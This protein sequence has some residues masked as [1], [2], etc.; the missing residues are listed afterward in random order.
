MDNSKIVALAL[1]CVAALLVIMA[2][3]SCASDIQEQNK[4]S[5]GSSYSSVK[6]TTNNA[7][8]R[9]IE[10]PPSPGQ[11]T[12]VYI[13]QTEANTESQYEV[14]TDMLGRVVET[15]PVTS[16]ENETSAEAEESEPETTLSLID[17]MYENERQ[18]ATNEISGFY[19]GTPEQQHKKELENATFPDDFSITID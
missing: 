7:A 4:K 2:G 16:A 10:D 9:L 18:N 12:P 11:G 13:E 17:Q 1:G 19:H 6:S 8:P 15:I 14:V 3:K 5:S